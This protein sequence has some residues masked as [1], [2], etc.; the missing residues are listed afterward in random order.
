MNKILWQPS[1]QKS[2][3]SILKDFS[4]FI[5]F[6]SSQNFKELW[7]WSV[8]NPEV[9]WEKFWDYSKIIGDKGKIILK[10]EK[11][12]NKNIFFP[13]AKLNYAENI[14]KKKSN[15]IAINFMSESG[16][17]ESIT[18]NL[19][20]EKVCKFSHYLRRTLSLD[21][22]YLGNILHHYKL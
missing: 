8:S 2:E 20:Y 3:N 9:F 5:E 7:K 4:N 16:F 17:E 14:L 12:F 21:V 19:L 11:V 15:D 13:D 10:K 22:H 1:K 6:K 18:W